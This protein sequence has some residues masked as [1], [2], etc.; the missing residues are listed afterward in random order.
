MKTR[1]NNDMVEK[2]ITLRQFAKGQLTVTR[3]MP[4]GQELDDA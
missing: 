3:D 1:T 4:P 2:S